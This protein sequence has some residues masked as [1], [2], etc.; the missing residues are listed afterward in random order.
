MQQILLCYVI[1]YY[2]N[3]NNKYFNFFQCTVLFFK[4]LY[5]FLML[6]HLLL[7]SLQQIQ[8]PLIR[9]ETRVH[10][11]LWGD[12]RHYSRHK[13]LQ[14]SGDHVSISTAIT[15]H[16]QLSK[17]GCNLPP[18]EFFAATLFFSAFSNPSTDGRPAQPPAHV[19]LYIAPG[20][21]GEPRQR[22]S[23]RCRSLKSFLSLD[24][25]TWT[26]F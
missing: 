4:I 18:G 6:L 22:R 20:R 19:R 15:I 13:W 2:F 16:D 25:H 26:D 12:D 24:I 14:L 1:L 3:Y 10:R 5:K 9:D 11:V 23:S 21:A 7:I 8:P 17:R